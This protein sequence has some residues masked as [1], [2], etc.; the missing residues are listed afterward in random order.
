MEKIDSILPTEYTFLNVK[1]TDI[2][3]KDFQIDPARANFTIDQ[4]RH[5]VKLDWAKLVNYQFH[6]HVRFGIFF[7][8][9]VNWDLDVYLKNV[10]LNNGFTITGN[11]HTGAPIFNLYSTNLDLGDS[12]YRMSGNFIM[13]LVSWF[14]NL[15]LKYPL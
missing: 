1:F 15:L 10:L 9:A 5:G 13:W 3:F 8:I 14:T 12:Y 7:F 4:G 11:P 2:H 6:C